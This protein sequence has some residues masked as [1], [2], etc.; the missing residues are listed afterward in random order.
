MRY[1][2]YGRSMGNTVERQIEA[3]AWMERSLKNSIS[4]V[5][6]DDKKI[7]GGDWNGTMVCWSRDGDVCW[8]A[9]LGDRVSGIRLSKDEKMLWC[10]AGREAIGIDYENGSIKWKIEFDGS[11][12]LIELDGEHR[13]WIVS[14]V[15][16]IELNDFMESAISLIDSGNIIEKHILDE[17]PWSIHSVREGHAFFGLGRPRAG[18]LELIE[19]NGKFTVS[20]KIVHDSPVL[21]GSN[22]LPFF[23]GHSNGMITQIN[24]NGELNNFELNK[25]NDS[26]IIDL[27]SNDEHIFLFLENKE[28][29]C[30]DMK[31]KVTESVEI[32]G[33]EGEPE[34]LNLIDGVS[35]DGYANFWTITSTMNGAFLIDTNR[36]VGI[37]K[38]KL[39]ILVNSRIRDIANAD[40]MTV[41]GLD[42]GRVISIEEN[43][44]KRRIEN[45]EQPIDEGE[46][47]RLDM[48]ERLR[49]LRE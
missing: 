39:K 1:P 23:I 33:S 9:D 31:G 28:I 30:V 4:T 27:A 3:V 34:F 44:L 22:V 38:I 26:A 8:E 47:H 16:D 36:S 35:T 40:G 43:M 10:I 25:K 19:K 42:D 6:I 41:I 37:S 2:R 21:C 14:S 48:R 20:H 13:A 46:G 49:K 24:E 18:V 29:L 7:I 45:E 17:R 11:T 5:Y 15:Y 12:D 32:S